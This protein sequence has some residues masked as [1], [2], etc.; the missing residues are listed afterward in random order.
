M[1]EA[2]PIILGTS[3]DAEKKGMSGK[4]GFPENVEVPYNW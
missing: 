1:E 2:L 4:K 3:H